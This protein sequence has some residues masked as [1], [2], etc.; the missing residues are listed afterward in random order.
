MMEVTLFSNV[1]TNSGRST[2]LDDPD[3]PFELLERTSKPAARGPYP[4]TLASDR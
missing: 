1:G 2:S 3:H 4:A